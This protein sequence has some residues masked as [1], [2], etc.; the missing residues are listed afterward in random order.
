MLQHQQYDDCGS[1]T[2][3][4]VSNPI[5][6]LKETK[7]TPLKHKLPIENYFGVLKILGGQE[8]GVKIIGG[9][10]DDLEPLMPAPL[11]DEDYETE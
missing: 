6:S 3:L 9:S 10:V 11:D 2:A 1:N 8:P 5:C 4:A 7:T